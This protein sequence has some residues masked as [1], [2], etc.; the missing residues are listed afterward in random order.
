M[1][2][3]EEILQKKTKAIIPVHMSGS[4][5]N[6]DKIRKISKKFK[7]PV[8]EDCAHAF[9]A[10]YSDGSMI[11]SCKFSDI[12]VFSFHPVKSMTTGEGGVITTNSKSIYLKL[13]RLRSHGINKSNDKFI[14][15][16]TLTQMVN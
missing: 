4:A 15:K 16:K 3:L 7:V 14:N 11:G 12:S 2:K 5:Y 9:G 8:I 1:N 13:L 10:K 6:M